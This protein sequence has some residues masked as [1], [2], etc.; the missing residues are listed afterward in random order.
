MITYD[1]TEKVVV[2]TG[3][4]RGIGKRIAQRFVQAGAHV[5]VCRKSPAGLDELEA[6]LLS[7]WEG[8]PELAPTVH[9]FALDID[10]TDAIPLFFERVAELYNHIDILVNNAGIMTS[11]ELSEITPERY[12]QVMDT[13]VK[14][15]LFCSQWFAGY[16]QQQHTPGVIVNMASVSSVTYIPNNLLY[17]I[18]KASVV[19][20]TKTLARALGPDG[21]RVNAVGPGSTPTDMNAT[22]YADPERERALC[23]KLPLGRRATKDDIANCVLFL[24]SDAADYVTG[25]VLYAEGGW[26]LV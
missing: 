11:E 19:T 7:A 8:S 26:L 21:I 2:V 13:N 3:G 17:N 16:H 10:D 23:E 15:M 25:Q 9:A 12:D 14:G 1:F 18:S 20:L 24:A 22:L 6:E 4:G 5:V